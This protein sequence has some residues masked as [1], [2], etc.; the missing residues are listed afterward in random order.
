MQP[1]TIDDCGNLF[2]FLYA[3]VLICFFT[4]ASNISSSIIS[5]PNAYSGFNNE[6]RFHL[7]FHN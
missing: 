1:H 6:Y 4:P 5:F 2:P 3:A 7:I